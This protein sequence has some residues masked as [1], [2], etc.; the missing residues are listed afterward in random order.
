M[1]V[2]PMRPHYRL[3]IARL[4]AGLKQQELADLLGVG[5]TVVSNAETGIRAPRATVLHAWA[6]ATGVPVAWLEHGDEAPAALVV[7]APA[8][9]IRRVRWDDGQ[10]GDVAAR[11]I[12]RAP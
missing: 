8:P 4:E 10:E 6:I 5:R 9:G 2:P 7:S 11:D 1:K 12:G 3:L